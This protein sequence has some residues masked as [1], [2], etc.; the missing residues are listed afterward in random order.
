MSEAVSDAVSDPV[1]N[2]AWRLEQ[3]F[4]SRGWSPFAFQR[5]VWQAYANGESGLIHA[6]TG[7]GKTYAAW[8]G[9]VLEA[10]AEHSAPRTLRRRA[11]GA[12]L[13]VPWITP[14]VS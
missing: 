12:P 8:M 7:T 2:A 10:L 6:A 14:L 4:A 3:W 11:D 9:P 1:G 13:R 5:D